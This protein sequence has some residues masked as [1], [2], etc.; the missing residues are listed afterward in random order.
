MMIQ[1]GIRG[2]LLGRSDTFDIPQDT[3][4]VNADLSRSVNNNEESS[5][6]AMS[7]PKIDDPLKILKIRFAK[8]EITKEQYEEMR[9]M[10]ES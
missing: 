5:Q 4:S 1:K 8:G 3:A 9:R 10:L 7:S 2:E 6:E